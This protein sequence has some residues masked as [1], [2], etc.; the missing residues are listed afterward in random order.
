MAYPSTNGLCKALW[1]IQRFPICGRIVFPKMVTSNFNSPSFH[2]W[3]LQ[4]AVENS[5]SSHLWNDSLSKNGTAYP[6]TDGLCKALWIIQRF[7]ICGRV[8]FPKM[9]TSNFNGLSFHRWTL[10]SAVENSK[11][12]HLWKDSLYKNG[13]LKFQRPILPQM[14]FAKRCGEFKDFPSVE[15]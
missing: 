7:P 6:S 10:Q 13:T 8:A 4:S 2:R 3:T 11:I 9:V 1:K 14:D 15:G 12:S 5:K